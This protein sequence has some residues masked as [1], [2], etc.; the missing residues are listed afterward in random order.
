[1]D[2][3]LRFIGLCLGKEN[4]MSAL[5]G[6]FGISRKTGYK[7]LS[8]YRERGVEGLED[9]SRASH[10][11]VNSVSPEVESEIVRLRGLHPHWG[12]RKL[13]SWFL[14]HRRR[15]LWPAASTIGEILRRHGLVVRRRCRRKSPPYQEPFI[16]CDRPNA[17][18]CADFKG[19]FR[20]GDGSRC[21]PFTLT[22][23][24][25]R[26]L[27]R[28]QAVVRPD[29]ESVRPLFQAAFQEY[30]LPAAIR[31]DNGSPFA[32]VSVGGL[33]KLSIEWIKLGIIPER[34]AP[35]HPEQNGRHERMH[36]TLKAETAT[37]ASANLR[38]QQ[39]R[40]DRFRQE[41]NGERPHEALGQKPPAQLYTPSFR[42]WP[43]RLPE[44]VYPDHY[45]LRKVHHRGDLRCRNTSIYLS[46]TLIGE[47]LGL[48]QQDERLFDVYFSWLKLGTLDIENYTFKREHQRL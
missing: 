26:Y 42:P 33:S 1:M 8:R 21:D 32:T 12:S 28:C 25:S 27:L 6:S 31:T 2:E 30:G 43:C 40:F 14:S 46:E 45:L 23:A 34:I 22:D 17:V 18:W 47:T 13:R 15:E 10:R 20:T 16:G 48:D 24:Y 39:H 7:W 38:R 5:C 11:H 29:Y 36:R 19:W 3:R 4:G 44:I 41:Y 9:E 35:G 37:P